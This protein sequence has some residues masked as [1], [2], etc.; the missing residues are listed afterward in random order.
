MKIGTERVPTFTPPRVDLGDVLQKAKGTDQLLDPGK[1]NKELLMVFG[2]VQNANGEW[3]ERRFQT[4]RT[5]QGAWSLDGMLVDTDGRLTATWSTYQM[6]LRNEVPDLSL[7]S[8]LAEMQKRDRLL[9][10]LIPL[11]NSAL[12]WLEEKPDPVPASIQEHLPGDPLE[13]THYTD[14]SSTDFGFRRIADLRRVNMARIRSGKV[15]DGKFAQRGIVRGRLG[16]W[17]NTTSQGLSYSPRVFIE[18]SKILPKQTYISSKPETV[19]LLEGGKPMNEN[20]PNVQVLRTAPNLT[21]QSFIV[22]A[23][24]AFSRAYEGIPFVLQYDTYEPW[25]GHFPRHD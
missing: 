4:L 21:G 16:F 9:I 7:P 24:I 17:E 10:P 1:L 15:G 12:F 6:Y 8:I 2:N 13:V 19:V 18:K 22:A 3:I 20:H 11:R 23:L 5:I 14:F 25:A